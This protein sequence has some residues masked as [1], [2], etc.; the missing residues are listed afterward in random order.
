MES[1]WGIHMAFSERQIW[2]LRKR[3]RAYREHEGRRAGIRRG[4]PWKSVA[5]RI[6][7]RLDLSF[8]IPPERLRQFAEGLPDQ[9]QPG[10]IRFPQLEAHRLEALRQF[11]CCDEIALL[12]NSEFR[13]ENE[14]VPAV[15]HGLTEIYPLAD[16]E[17]QFCGMMEGIYENITHND[18]YV[19]S[20][21]ITLQRIKP[22][23]VFQMDETICAYTRAGNSE[24]LRDW[25][26]AFRK[27]ALKSC[28]K[29]SGWLVVSFLPK[30]VGMLS[31]PYEV[32][33]SI[34]LV[35]FY[36]SDTNRRI[37]LAKPTTTFSSEIHAEYNDL[38][39]NETDR[40]GKSM[41]ILSAPPWMN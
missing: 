3:V 7:T 27:R 8:E 37:L 26:P 4:L 9:N 30:A 1:S 34:D 21:E 10:A 39:Y 19:F 18:R 32:P 13:R 28:K 17:R 25:P 29:R 12:N 33:Q 16:H 5:S 15:A 11:L 2:L 38:P 20:H 40:Y 23:G 22:D 41:A 31:R 14:V 36:K 24:N 35:G 6:E